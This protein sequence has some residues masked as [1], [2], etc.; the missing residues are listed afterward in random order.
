MKKLCATADFVLNVFG[1]A[2]VTGVRRMAGEQ[3]NDG[4]PVQGVEKK[5]A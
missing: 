3:V 2:V 4:C 1:A 5:G